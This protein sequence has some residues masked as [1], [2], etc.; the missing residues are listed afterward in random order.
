M[1]FEVLKQNPWRF[2]TLTTLMVIETLSNELEIIF[3][4]LLS[5]GRIKTIINAKSW[6]SLVKTAV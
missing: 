2:I 1:F 4:N 3:T 6:N 5:K